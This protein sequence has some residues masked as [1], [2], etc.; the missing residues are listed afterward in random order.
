MMTSMEELVALYPNCPYAIE[1]HEAWNEEIW[2]SNRAYVE[3][4]GVERLMD[5]FRMTCCKALTQTGKSEKFY[6]DGALCAKEIETD[7][8]RKYLMAKL[9]ML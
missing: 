2:N 3:K 1:V 9:G 8:F 6:H 4:N 7:D 5:L